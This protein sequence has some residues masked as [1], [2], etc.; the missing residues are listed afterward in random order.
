MLP[1]SPF[2]SLP[3]KEPLNMGSVGVVVSR[4]RPKNNF[5]YVPEVWTT[6][7]EIKPGLP[8]IDKEYIP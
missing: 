1:P 8:L 6:V 2:G 4:G 5:G 3:F 7:D